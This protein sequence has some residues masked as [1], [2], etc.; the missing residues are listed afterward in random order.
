M[1][2]ARWYGIVTHGMVIVAVALVSRDFNLSL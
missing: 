2:S 1:S